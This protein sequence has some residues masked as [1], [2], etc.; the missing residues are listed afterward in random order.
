M[1]CTISTYVPM[2]LN[3]RRT[4]VSVR[5]NNY[6]YTLINRMTKKRAG[7]LLV[8]IT[9]FILDML[10]CYKTQYKKTSTI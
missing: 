9:E 2:Q 5:V 3:P 10:D 1:I 6:K 7:I 8:I 4:R